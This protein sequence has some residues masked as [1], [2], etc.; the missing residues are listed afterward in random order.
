M[1]TA[2]SIIGICFLI[3]VLQLQAAE[4]SLVVV[5]DAGGPSTQPY[6]SALQL[7]TRHGDRHQA[8]TIESVAAPTEPYSEAHM[9]PV[10][11]QRL[12]PGSIIR[13]ATASPGIKPMFIVG[14]DELSRGWL[15]D[16]GPSLRHL[17]AVGFVVNV[18]TKASLEALRRL[19]PGLTLIPASGDEFAAR[20]GLQ[21]YPVLVT[22]TGI[23][24]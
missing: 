11:T 23:E 16:H 15:H 14:D 4:R 7:P 2:R 20:L 24:Q 12:S 22:A 19:A 8:A 10:R 5:H 18:E 3:Y 1:R 17:G 9:L 6:Y 13:R 21:H